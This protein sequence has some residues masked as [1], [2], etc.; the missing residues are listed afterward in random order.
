LPETVAVKLSLDALPFDF[1]KETSWRYSENDSD[2]FK[3]QD[4]ND[5]L[6]KFKP[7]TLYYQEDIPM[8][9][10]NGIAWF[11]LK[12]VVDSDL[13]GIPL[14]QLRMNHYGASEVYTRW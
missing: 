12:C 10:F 9:H 1:D 4:Y 7:T 5:K 11:R 13:V 3:L 14:A 2:V 6:W 8:N